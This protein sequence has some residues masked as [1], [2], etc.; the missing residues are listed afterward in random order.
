M[1]GK[2]KAKIHLYRG[3]IKEWGI[4]ESIKNP[5]IVKRGFTKED[6]LLCGITRKNQHEYFSRREEWKMLPFNR[7]Y[8]GACSDKLGLIRI[9]HEHKEVLPKY[10]F[11]IDRYG[12]LPLW[13]HPDREKLDYRVGIEKF[14]NLFLYNGISSLIVKPTHSE[15]GRGVIKVSY[16]DGEF[17][18]NNKK[19]TSAE[20][21]KSIIRCENCIVTECVENNAWTKRINPFSLNTIRMLGIWNGEKKEFEIIRSYHRFGCNGNIVDNA[22]SGNGILVWIDPDT[23]ITMKKG[24][25]NINDSGEIPC[26]NPVHPNSNVELSGMQIPGYLEMKQKVLRILNENSYLRYVGFDVAMTEDGFRIIEANGR[27]DLTQCLGGLLHDQR[28]VTLFKETS[29]K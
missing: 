11:Y 22:G 23:G 5:W 1:F 15:V 13:D 7:P 8:Q 20:L 16:Q 17:Y 14:R 24:L 26:D 18:I 6:I 29:R 4:V 9:L 27:S 21:E 25:Y 19:I 28:I 2:I 3:T 10:Y 12:L